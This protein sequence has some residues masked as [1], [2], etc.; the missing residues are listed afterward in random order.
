MTKRVTIRR[1]SAS[2]QLRPGSDSALTGTP[3]PEEGPCSGCSAP[4]GKWGPRGSRGA[5]SGRGGASKSHG[6]CGSWGDTEDEAQDVGPRSAGLGRA[7]R[8]AGTRAARP[9]CGG[10]E[11][12]TAHVVACRAPTSKP[13][14]CFPFARA[15]ALRRGTPAPG[16]Q[17]VAELPSA[18]LDEPD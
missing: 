6:P 3:P 4:L 18:T 8:R 15:A 11:S 7:P 1:F 14:S 13:V 17:Y 12:E 9:E 2:Q 5:V 16:C 10:R